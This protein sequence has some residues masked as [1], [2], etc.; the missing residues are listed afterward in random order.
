MEGFQQFD[1]ESGLRSSRSVVWLANVG[2][3]KS[4]GYRTRSSHLEEFVAVH[5][6]AKPHYVPS[7]PSSGIGGSKFPVPPTL[8]FPSV[9]E[10]CEVITGGSKS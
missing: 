6:V 1:G 3:A 8:I 2:S 4:S 7:S 9:M 5:V 10:C